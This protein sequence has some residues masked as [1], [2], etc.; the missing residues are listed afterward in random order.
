MGE[1]QQESIVPG[2]LQ[3]PSGQV[4]PTSPLHQPVHW[5][6]LCPKTAS[7]CAACLA[8]ETCRNRCPLSFV[9][10]VLCSAAHTGVAQ[11]YEGYFCPPPTP[12][13]ALLLLP[14]TIWFSLTVQPGCEE[15]K[16]ATFVTHTSYLFCVLEVK[17]SGRAVQ[18]KFSKKWLNVGAS[19]LCCYCCMDIFQLWQPW[20]AFRSHLRSIIITTEH[21]MM[22]PD[23]PAD[24]LG[25]KRLLIR[26]GVRKVGEALGGGGLI[27]VLSCR[28]TL[29]RLEMI[30]TTA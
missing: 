3:P 19:H 6:L 28:Q 24:N 17:T 2:L 14:Y 25:L 4:W 13:P 21:Q 10:G 27:S 23:R 9:A 16:E 5:S 22:R 26:A 18:S 11:F 29:R 15:V 12:P 7:S 30:L 8:A 20:R 1:A